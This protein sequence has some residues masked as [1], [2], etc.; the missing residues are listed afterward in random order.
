MA[1]K[2]CVLENELLSVCSSLS[3][4]IRCPEVPSGLATIKAHAGYDSLWTRSLIS[5]GLCR[6]IVGRTGEEHLGEL[7]ALLTLYLL[8]PNLH[9]EPHKMCENAS[10]GFCLQLL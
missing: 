3:K 7:Q 9:S 8:L 6:V 10:C 1:L 5:G 4:V 2:L